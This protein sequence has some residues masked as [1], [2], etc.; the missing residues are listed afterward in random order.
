MSDSKKNIFTTRHP[1]FRLLSFS[2]IVV[3][4]SS[5]SFNTMIKRS[6]FIKMKHIV[7][8]V[9]AIRVL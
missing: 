8:Q 3:V 7:L 9:L 4:L 1:G 6:D 2:S 5:I